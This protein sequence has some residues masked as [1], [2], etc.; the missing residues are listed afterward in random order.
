MWVKYSL[1]R[2]RI[3]HMLNFNWKFLTPLAL[4]SMM[5]T[6]VLDKLLAPSGT[7]IYAVGMLAA[8]IVIIWVTLY[9]L[10][11]Y[12]HV[13][14]QRVAEPKPIAAPELGRAPKS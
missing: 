12:A 4:A 5:V 14:R 9:I 3:D 8:N 7:V 1:P 6:A 2:I 10:G 13:E 11:S